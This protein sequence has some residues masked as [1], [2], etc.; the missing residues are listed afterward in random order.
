MSGL[1]DDKPIM[2]VIA[3]VVPG[4]DPQLPNNGERKRRHYI[5]EIWDPDIYDRKDAY[6]YV[7]PREGELV[8][9]VKM[10]MTYEVTH[11]DF[12]GKRYKS[13]LVP[14]LIYD[15]NND[16][17]DGNLIF[18]L[19]G[20][21]NQGERVMAVDYS[22]RPN[23]AVI[24]GRIV[25]PNA[26]YGLVYEG[27]VVGDLGKV[28]SAM[29]N[30]ST[31]METNHV[32]VTLAVV[33]DYTNRVIMTT[34][35]FSVVLNAEELPDGSRAT[36]VFFDVNGNYIPP[37]YRLGVQH[38]AYLKHHQVGKK[39]VK[40]IELICPWFT[41]SNETDLIY[42]PFNVALQSVEFR[43]LVHFSDGS[44]TEHVVDGRKM[45]LYG[46]A[47][48]KPT[49]P[50]QESSIVLSYSFD[51]SEEVYL[52]TPG[53]PKHMSK[54]YR[55]QTIPVNGSYS[56]RIY[57]YPV[58]DKTAY[59]LRHYLYDL[60][61]NFAIDVTAFVKLNDKSDV[62]SPTKYGIEQNMI[63]NLTLRDAN[64]TF[65][66]WIHVQHTTITLFKDIN[67]PGRRWDVRHSY[68]KPAYTAIPVKVVNSGVNTTVNLTAGFATQKEWLAGLYSAIEP[69][70]DLTTEEFPPTP[71]HFEIC[72]LT[73]QR[74]RFPIGNW[75]KA[76]K[77]AVEL[78]IGNTL[79]IRWF[80]VLQ[81]G[82]ELQL[83]ITGVVADNS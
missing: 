6:K 13:T 40:G 81:N 18:G 28:I 31:V 83:G 5:E 75:N 29:Y 74:F 69:L 44:S 78:P 72:D 55:I 76:N 47:E 25:C 77:I 4:T 67:G 48:H 34:D 11:V 59:K 53:A 1:F 49:T 35:P 68:T 12:Q 38:S 24:D 37:V 45:S 39:Y 7:V 23:R 3:E 2:P 65:S 56:P 27:N 43:A 50:G 9:D 26:A 57:T 70:Y 21:F 66:T 15:D 54:S 32:P 42:L 58:W 30:S 8:D 33:K 36:L 62:F 64:P 63:F 10:H 60:N 17:G 52:A 82:T 19:P 61:R 80:N 71:T 41:N 51:D 20:G 14:W 73:N 46:L 16:Q 79:F 22:V